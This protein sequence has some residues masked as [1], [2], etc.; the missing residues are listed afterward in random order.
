MVQ[1]DPGLLRWATNC[2]DPAASVVSVTG[3]RRG[4]SPWLVRLSSSHI[5]EVVV[6]GGDESSVALLATEAAALEAIVASDVPGPRLLGVA[7][8]G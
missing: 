8:G 3:L 2:V 6:R 5:G 4:E 7:M 1:P